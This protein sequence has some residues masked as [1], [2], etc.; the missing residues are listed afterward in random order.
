MLTDLAVDANITD[1][2]V[3]PHAFRHTMVGTLI[4]NGNSMEQASNFLGHKNV[5]TTNKFY[6]I[7]TVK[8]LNAQ[9]NNPFMP[10]FKSKSERK[11]EEGETV[12]IQQKKIQT[13]LQI[14]TE[15]NRI[16]ATCV[17]E[18]LPASEVQRMLFESMPDLGKI[19]RVISETDSYCQSSVCDTENAASERHHSDSE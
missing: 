18:G 11:E 5:D 14:I 4:E 3:H 10:G 7:A 9:M 6:W 15:Y 13:C 17:D 8:E 2:H 12:A 1:V 16:T 19:L